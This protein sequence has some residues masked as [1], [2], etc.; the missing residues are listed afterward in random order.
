[1]VEGP[2]P[3][4]F[5]RERNDMA[6]SGGGRYE[7]ETTALLCTEEADLVMVIV[8]GGKRG[9]GFS[10]ASRGTVNYSVLTKILKS[11]VKQIDDSST[12][13]GGG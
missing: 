13:E 4:G 12:L 7:A 10:V 2:V 6:C 3:D 11:T 9:G 5:I 8:I 1:M